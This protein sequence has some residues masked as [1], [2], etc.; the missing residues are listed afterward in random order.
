MSIF[1]KLYQKTV[2]SSD[3]RGEP[4]M[5][6]MFSFILTI[7]VGLPIIYLSKIMLIGLL[8][9]YVPILVLLFMISGITIPKDGDYRSGI[10]IGI[11][12]WPISL[13]AIT[14]C[15]AGILMLKFSKLIYNFH[16]NLNNVKL[17]KFPKRKIKNSVP[18]SGTYRSSPEKCDSCGRVE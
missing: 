13:T 1:Q 2:C 6:F 11:A 10:L 4:S 12:L 14:M 16:G 9:S 3:H 7:A 5:L 18:N 8:M 17:P 15:W